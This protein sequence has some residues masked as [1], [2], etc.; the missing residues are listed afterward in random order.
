MSSALMAEVLFLL[1]NLTRLC[2]STLVLGLNFCWG[3]TTNLCILST[4][5]QLSPAFNMYSTLA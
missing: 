5:T 1:D 3:S 2:V 4:L